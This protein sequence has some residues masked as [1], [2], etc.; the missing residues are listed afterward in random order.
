M[1][2]KK[3]KKRKNGC[4]YSI[5]AQRTENCIYSHKNKWKLKQK[6]KTIINNR[7]IGRVRETNNPFICFF[8]SNSIQKMYPIS[9]TKCWCVHNKTVYATHLNI[10]SFS[11]ASKSTISF[12]FNFCSQHFWAAQFNEIAMWWEKIEWWTYVALCA[13]YSA[14][15]DV[16]KF[17]KNLYLHKFVRE[18]FVICV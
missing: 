16:W 14:V 6:K 5:W 11:V 10:Y 3:K 17:H 1:E 13:V 15:F 18:L 9:F 7:C 8:F 2:R 4:A 12:H